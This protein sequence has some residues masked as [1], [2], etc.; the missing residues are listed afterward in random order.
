MA[1]FLLRALGDT[2]IP[3]PLG[4]FADVPGDAW[5]RPWVDRLYERGITTGCAPGR[6]CPSS[7]VRRDE[8]ATF[9]TRAFGFTPI[10][11]PPPTTT[12]T[13]PLPVSFG[14]GI[15][16]VGIDIPAG[17]YR[18]TGTSA[19]YWARLS[20]FGGTLGEIISNSFD[21]VPNIVTIA[22]TDKGF[23]SNRCGTW[24]N[25][26]KPRTASPTSSHGGGH[27]VVGTEV[28]PGTWQSSSTGSCYWERLRGFG[29]TLD[30]IIANDFADGPRVVSISSGDR[31]FYASSDCG[32]W[33]Y[34]G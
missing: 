16:K 23:E 34:L 22:A 18:N 9:L 17:T 29:G 3:A 7:P 5:Y 1:A 4:V 24:A 21:D 25:N 12:T 19:C 6:Y 30:E 26:F 20:G 2:N 11:P 14:N 13:L 27:F 10:V 33:S 32:M 31:G 28:A 8:M 15:W